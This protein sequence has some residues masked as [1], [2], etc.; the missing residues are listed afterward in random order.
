[1]LR[2]GAQLHIVTDSLVDCRQ[3]I[4]VQ[5]EFEVAAVVTTG[6]EDIVDVAR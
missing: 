4:F 3:R 5:L 1:M 2:A 6:V